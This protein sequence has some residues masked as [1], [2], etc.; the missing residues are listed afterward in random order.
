MSR[1]TAT[2]VRLVSSLGNGTEESAK[3]ETLGVE[4]CGVWGGGV[5][6][7]RGILGLRLAADSRSFL[8]RT[9][10]E[11]PLEEPNERKTKY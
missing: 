1:F 5:P 8:C 6:F 10:S 3:T 2:N 7:K 9:S 11:S 4:K